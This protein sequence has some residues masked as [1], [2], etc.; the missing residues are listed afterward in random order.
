MA[1]K[2]IKVSSFPYSGEDGIERTALRGEKVDVNGADLKRGERLEAFATDDD[3]KPGTVFGDFYAATQGDPGQVEP[4]PVV[5]QPEA[6][7]RGTKPAD[8]KS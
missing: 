5:T 3:L 7:R 8:S 4:E 1:E 6:P 2:I